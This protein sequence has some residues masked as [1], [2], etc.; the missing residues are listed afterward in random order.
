MTRKLRMTPVRGVTCLRIIPRCIVRR[1]HPFKHLIIS[2]QWRESSHE[3][4]VK[5]ITEG[6]DKWC[7]RLAIIVLVLKHC[8]KQ[9]VYMEEPRPYSNHAGATDSKRALATT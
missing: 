5:C 2:A 8:R 9:S 3:G 7:W 6:L 1:L 4:Y